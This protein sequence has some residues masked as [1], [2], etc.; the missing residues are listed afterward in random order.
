M[1]KRKYVKDLIKVATKDIK[2]SVA[3]HDESRRVAFLDKH[4]CPIITSLE[5][6]GHVAYFENYSL[7]IIDGQTYRVSEKMVRWQLRGVKGRRRT[8]PFS[9]RISELK[10][11]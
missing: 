2:K 4:S 8:L 7:L 11:A 1:S 10:L 6:H 5:R 3:S 9:F